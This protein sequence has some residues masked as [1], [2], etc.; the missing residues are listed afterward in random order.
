M[1][2]ASY[3]L[4]NTQKSDSAAILSLDTEKAFARL[5][6]DNLWSVL[7]YMG[8]GTQF[9]SMIKIL[10]TNPMAMVIF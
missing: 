1:C 3:T 8:F 9:I 10:Y 5:E 6:W 7:H 4:L 2:V